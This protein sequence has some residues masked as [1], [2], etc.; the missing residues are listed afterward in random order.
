MLVLG[1]EVP[2]LPANN[3]KT[4]KREDKKIK[5]SRKKLSELCLK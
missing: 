2:T 1:T 4:K 3:E 5:N